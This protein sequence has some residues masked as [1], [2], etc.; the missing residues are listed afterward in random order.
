MIVR[1]VAQQGV[2]TRGI[3]ISRATVVPEVC[4]T[5]RGVYWHPVA[6]T[7]PAMQVH[8][9]LDDLPG[10]VSEIRREFLDYRRRGEVLAATFPC[11]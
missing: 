5:G 6:A 10:A 8:D 11:A 9:H 1:R 3:V 7:D 4:V 2:A